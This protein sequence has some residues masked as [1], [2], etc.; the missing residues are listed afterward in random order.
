MVPGEA[1]IMIHVVLKD[2]R[3]LLGPMWVWRPLEG[4]FELGGVEERIHLADAVSAESSEP[5]RTHR[6]HE[7]CIRCGSGC[8]GLET[9]DYLERARKQIAQ[10]VERV[11]K[12]IEQANRRHEQTLQGDAILLNIMLVCMAHG[13]CRV[14]VIRGIEFGLESPEKA[15]EFLE[16]GVRI[17]ALRRRDFDA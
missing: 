11:S 9:V 13:G 5:E 17:G 6:P 10:A 16:Q 1:R 15:R 7:G 8:E 3:E 12:Q 14:G 4:W 2:G